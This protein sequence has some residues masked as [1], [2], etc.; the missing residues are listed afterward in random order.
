[1]DVC[2]HCGAEVRQV[3]TKRGESLV[4]DREPVEGGRF[5]LIVGIQ[6]GGGQG[7]IGV[8]ASLVPLLFDHGCSTYNRHECPE[9]KERP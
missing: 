9:G 4:L 7:L 5:A 1:M 6:S 3:E 8:A 2:E